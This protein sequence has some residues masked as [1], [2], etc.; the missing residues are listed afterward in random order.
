MAEV[1][2][3]AYPYAGLTRARKTAAGIS[4]PAP[5]TLAE[6]RSRAGDGKQDAA[7]RANC[8]G[9]LRHGVLRLANYPSTTA[10]VAVPVPDWTI[11]VRPADRL[12]PATTMPV[13]L[14]RLSASGRRGRSSA[15]RP[16]RPEPYDRREASS[17]RRH[18]ASQRRG[19]LW[20]SS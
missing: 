11:P 3:R 2:Q 6:V 14:N 18:S 13:A 12:A 9:C 19:L 5:P 1:G 20:R 15:P 4:K 7:V 10:T 17:E 8:G 16:M